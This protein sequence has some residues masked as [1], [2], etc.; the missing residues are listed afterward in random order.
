MRWDLGLPLHPREQG[1]IDDLEAS[2][3]AS[4]KEV[5]DST[6]CRECDGHCFL[7]CLWSSVGWFHTSWLNNK[8][9]CL[10][11]ETLKRLKEAIR[12]K[13][14]GLLTKVLLFHDNAQPHSAATTVNLQNSSTF[15]TQSWFGTVG[16]PP[17]LK[18]DK[19]PRRSA[20]PLQ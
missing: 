8:C 20:I 11:Q 10:D 19:A 9:S 5:Q 16:L 3:L 6:V 15:I 18:D 7:G 17:V 14:P 2:L 4:Q 1:W 12:K 13:K